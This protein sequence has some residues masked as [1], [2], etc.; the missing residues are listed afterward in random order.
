MRGTLITAALSCTLAL[1]CGGTDTT[2]TPQVTITLDPL[3]ATVTTGGTQ[4]FLAHVANSLDLS[5]NWSVVEGGA[6]GH[7]TGAGL[8]T[9]PA[10]AGTYHVKV[11]ANADTSVSQTATVTVTDAAAP[12]VISSFTA[13][14][15]S[16][17][18]GSTSTLSWATVNANSFGIDHGVVITSGSSVV[19]APTSTT[20]YTLTAIGAGGQTTAQAT[21]TV[22]GTTSTPSVP[23]I[24]SFT[25]TPASIQSGS[26][27]TLAWTVTG[28]TSISL[29]HGVNAGS[30][31]SVVVAPTSTVTYTL[32]AGNAAGTSTAQATVTVTAATSTPAAPVITGFTATPAILVQGQSTTL[33]WTLSGGAATL[34]IDHGLG[35]VTGSSTTTS[36]G[37]STTLHLT[38]SNSAGTSTAA[39]TITISPAAPLPVIAN[40]IATPPAIASGGSATL[41]WS[42]ANATSFQLNGNAV[43][44]TSTQV[45][46]NVTTSYTL[47]A[48]NAVGDTLAH[49]TVTLVAATTTPGAPTCS[50]ATF[51]VDTS[52]GNHAI[53]PYI[54]GYNAG[55]PSDAPAGVTMLRSGGNRWTAYNWETN[56]SNAGSDYLFENDNYLT[57]SSVPGEAVRPTVDAAHTAGLAALVTVPM[58]GYVS[59]DKNSQYDQNAPIASHFFPSLPRKGAAFAGSPDLNDKFVYQDEFVGHLL[60]QFPNAVTSSAPVFF[61]LDNEPDLWNSTH[62]EIERAALGY[63]ELLGKTIATSAAIKDVSPQALTFGPVSYGFNGFTTLQGALSNYTPNGE[64]W[65]LDKYLRDLKAAGDKQGRRLLDVLDLHWYTEATGGGV[66]VNSG[67]DNSSAV[68]AA[69]VQSPRSLWDPSY[70]ESSWITQYVLT[71]GIALIPRLRQKIADGYPGT[72]LAFTEYNHGGSDDITGAVA[73]ADTLGIFGREDVWAASFWPLLADNKFIHGA[74]RAFRDY[75]GAGGAFGDTSVR[76]TSSDDSKASIYASVDAGHPERVVLVAINKTTSSL[77][78]GVQV[79]HSQALHTAHLHQ[80]TAATPITNGAAVPQALADLTVTSNAFD[81]TLPAWSVT[82]IVLVP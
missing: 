71:S 81:L 42:A 82:T 59:A 17:Q 24:V 4:Q 20:T 23:V 79:A 49:T 44:G 46:P 50:A 31:T 14:P 7:V 12:P 11:V 64:D 21:V 68:Q 28:A 47:T 62:L 63:D 27:S 60:G 37:A 25:A 40:F 51:K 19:V 80:V 58:Q 13:S 75:D 43:S 53:S 18:K 35:V 57:S 41:S 9:A 30:G 36:P 74:F 55:T 73:Q 1:G 34:S 78:T 38:A 52:A 70:V 22:S 3:T 5:V 29:N 32:S 39:V 10:S 48:H 15:A 26:T 67:D 56:A 76:A 77:C 2:S 72:R 69:R 33:A 66:R 45:S 61:S 16:I 65:F 8:Y 54:Y 6:G